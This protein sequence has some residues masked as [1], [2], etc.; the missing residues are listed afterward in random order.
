MPAYPGKVSVVTSR[1]IISITLCGDENHK[2]AFTEDGYLCVNDNAK[3]Y[4]AYQTNEGHIMKLENEITKYEYIP[5]TLK[6]YLSKAYPK[7]SRTASFSKAA[8][9]SNNSDNMLTSIG[10]KVVV[11]NR[12]VLLVL[13]DFPD[14]RMTKTYNDFMR[15]FNEIGYHADGASGSVR[16]FYRWS[17]YGKLDLTCDVI[18]IYTSKENKAYYGG[19][20]TFSGNDERPYALFLEALE[21][22]ASQK[23]LS[24]YDSDGDGYIDNIHI[25]YAGHGEEAGAS[26]D[27]IWAHEMTF[28]ELKVQNTKINKYSC[29]PELRGNKGNGITRIGPIC[30]EIGHALGAMDYYDTN[31]SEKGGYSGTGKWDIMASGS[32]NNEGASPSDFNP[33][34]KTHDFGWNEAILLDSTKEGSYVCSN[35][36]IYKAET[37]KQNDYYLLTYRTNEG[38]TSHDPGEG[39]LIFHVGSDIEERSLT[40]TINATYP[41]QCYVVCAASENRVPDSNPQ[42]YGNIDTKDVTPFPGNSSNREFSRFSCPAAAT[43]QGEYANFYVANIENHRDYVSFDYYNDNPYNDY[44]LLWSDDFESFRMNSVWTSTPL[45]GSCNW[46]LTKQILPSSDARTPMPYSGI[47]YAK[48]INTQTLAVTELKHSAV[49][50]KKNAS[51]KFVLRTKGYSESK[52]NADSLWILLRSTSVERDTVIGKI[53]YDNSLKWQTTTF[54]FNVAGEYSIVLKTS[55]SKNS[56]IFLDKVELYEKETYQKGDVNHDGRITLSDANLIVNYYLGF[57]NNIDY[58][59]ADVNGDGRVTIEDANIVVNMFL[60]N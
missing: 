54:G 57:D 23:N 48:L 2:F 5:D 34:V 53:C 10:K 55:L 18:G 26:S 29:S 19:N 9:N 13:V 1:G 51:C 31:Y 40:N 60:N 28:R 32:W 42:T 6:Q 35:T 16:D 11:G 37:G 46:G 56:I 52:E 58:E 59:A 4:F 39:L 17:S 30:H 24:D 45:F 50:M 7:F 27:C 44:N 14:E 15:I 21:Y 41:Q 20:S 36:D 25:I 22:A 12:K 8:V 49:S 33:Y 43:I 38:F 47:G 3:W